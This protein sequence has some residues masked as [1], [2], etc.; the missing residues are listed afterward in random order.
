MGTFHMEG[1]R[2][3]RLMMCEDREH[4]ASC[5]PGQLKSQE[6]SKEVREKTPVRMAIRYGH[7]LPVSLRVRGRW[8]PA[9]DR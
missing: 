3:G 9:W 7:Q 2:L 5:D 4:S 6:I 8:T 1:G